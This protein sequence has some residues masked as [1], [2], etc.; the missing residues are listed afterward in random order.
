MVHG[1]PQVQFLDSFFLGSSLGKHPEQMFDKGKSWIAQCVLE[2]VH[3]DVAGPF[4]VPSFGKS[5][6]VLTFID[7]YSHFTWV[8][9]M[10]L[11]SEVFE[12]NLSF[13]AQVEK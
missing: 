7:D 5:R 8:F 9:L 4:P 1:L 11:K 2:L 13:K 12:K 6:Y 10:A 3:N